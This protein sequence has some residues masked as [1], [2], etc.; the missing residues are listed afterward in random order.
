MRFT[1]TD[2]T[3]KAPLLKPYG[4]DEADIRNISHMEIDVCNRLWTIDRV[5]K[6]LVVFDLLT[7]KT[8]IR[9]HKLHSKAL[10]MHAIS[11][12]VNASDCENA[13]VYMPYYAHNLTISIYHLKSDK[14][15]TVNEPIYPPYMKLF[16]YMTLIAPTSTLSNA[17]EDGY[18]TLYVQPRWSN[19][20][21]SISTKLLQTPE[22]ATNNPGPHCNILGINRENNAESKLV[23]YDKATGILFYDSNRGQHLGC[24]NP[25]K[26]GTE[27]S[28]KTIKD[29]PIFKGNEFMFALTGDAN[30]NLWIGTRKQVQRFP[31]KK[32]EFYVYRF[33]IKDFVNG[34]VCE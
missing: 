2:V 22:A 8:P 18:K 16:D 20:I 33:D 24:W 3:E 19:Y 30:G 14:S 34:S 9:K 5:H 23:H 17:N 32:D 31:M 26:F 1:L 29:S 7:N 13:Y 28:S 25:S 21:F 12:D 4:K 27:L 10:K 6:A 15:W 11:V